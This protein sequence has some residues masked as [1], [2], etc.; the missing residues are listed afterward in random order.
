MH[1]YPELVVPLLTRNDNICSKYIS[2]H[3]C[4]DVTPSTPPSDHRLARV[5]VILFER[6][7]IYC[8]QM[9]STAIRC[10]EQ[11]QPLSCDMS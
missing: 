7:V 10:F 8:E 9:M 5:R 3:M 1:V 2:Q 4:A 6:S 11:G